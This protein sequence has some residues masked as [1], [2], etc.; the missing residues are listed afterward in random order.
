[1][2]ILLSI[3]CCSPFFWFQ[4]VQLIR[5]FRFSDAYHARPFHSRLC[6]LVRYGTFLVT[7]GWCAIQYKHHWARACT[8]VCT[9]L[10]A[11]LY[12]CLHI[13][14]HTSIH[15]SAHNT[16]VCAGISASPKGELCVFWSRLVS[17]HMRTHFACIHASMSTFP[18]ADICPPPPPP[19]P[20]PPPGRGRT[21]SQ[22]LWAPVRYLLLSSFLCLN[23][24]A[25]LG[26]SPRSRCAW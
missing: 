14:T 2:C 23:P 21:P 19:R 9:W 24:L 13:H 22:G 11:C 26:T 4:D 25:M 5:P 18:H 15:R 20:P 10:H 6:S 12:T 16:L 1:M 17:I 8:L 7:N 3:T